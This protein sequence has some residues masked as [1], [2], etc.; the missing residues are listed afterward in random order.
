MKRRISYLDAKRITRYGRITGL[1]TVWKK[2]AKRL[3]DE[4]TKGLREGKKCPSA[5]PYV[6]LLAE[7]MRTAIPWQAEWTKLAKRLNPVGWKSDRK[8]LH[9]IYQVAG[10]KLDV[11]PN[12]KYKSMPAVEDRRVVPINAREVRRALGGGK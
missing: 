12:P 4:L 9:R 7:F 1:L 3:N 11:R 5:S 10:K 2:E 6:V 8:R